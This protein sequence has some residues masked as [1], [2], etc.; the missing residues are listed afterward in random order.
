MT[1][2]SKT[3]ETLEQALDHIARLKTL[4][5]LCTPAHEEL[6]WRLSITAHCWFGLRAD[7]TPF[8]WMREDEP[9]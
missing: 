8:P 5:A 1:E 2:L 3:P 4:L 7:E 6:E 9:V